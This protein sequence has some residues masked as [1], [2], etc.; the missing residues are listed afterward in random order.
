MSP[1]AGS[2][3][4]AGRASRAASTWCAGTAPTTAAPRRPPERSSAG[5]RPRGARSPGW[6]SGCA[7]N[8]SSGQ[9][10]VA[11]QNAVVPRMAGDDECQRAGADL[12]LIG[13]RAPPQLLV[14]QSAEQPHVGAPQGLQLVHQRADRAPFRVGL[15]RVYVL[16]EACERGLV[17]ARR[18]HRAIGED[19]L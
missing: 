8:G 11:E 19:A 15:V 1:A 16:V 10:A 3:A 13:D 17:S 18:A 2:G 5:S 14:A 4:G 9:V 12:V 7:E 6:P